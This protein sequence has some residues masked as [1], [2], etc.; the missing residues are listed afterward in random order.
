MTVFVF[1]TER[2]ICKN[3]QFFCYFQRFLDIIIFVLCSNVLT[4]KKKKKKVKFISSLSWHKPHILIWARN[5]QNCFFLLRSVQYSSIALAPSSGIL[6][7][8]KDFEINWDK[9]VQYS[10]TKM[11]CFA[12]TLWHLKAILKVL[13]VVSTTDFQHDSVPLSCVDCSGGTW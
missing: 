13:R 7:S 3:R 6:V 4:C 10:F 1:E 9:H 2:N 12:I 11:L 5:G 8:S